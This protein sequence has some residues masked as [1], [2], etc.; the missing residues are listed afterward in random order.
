MSVR[1]RLTLYFALLLCAI[2]IFS[3]LMLN[4]ILQRNLIGGV[5]AKLK[6]YTAQVHGILNPDEM[7]GSLDCYAIQSELP[8]INE[9]TSPTTYIQIIDRSGI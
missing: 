3:G 2:L 5:D 4:Y 6:L 9:F 8:L 7:S 1:W